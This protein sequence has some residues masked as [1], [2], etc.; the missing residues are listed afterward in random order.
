V[1]TIFVQIASYRDAQLLPTLRDLIAKANRPGRLR[2]GICWQRDETESLEELAHDP[3]LRVIDV[4]YRDAQGACWARWLTQ[5]LYESEDYT[6]QI[7]SHHRFVRGWDD[8]LIA[9]LKSTG[10]EKPILTAYAP[11]FEPSDT[12]G[13]FSQQ[14]W[15]LKFLPVRHHS[16]DDEAHIPQLGRCLR[17]ARGRD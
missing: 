8:E 5:S 7:D 3:R 4:N 13:V 6:L 14:P 17:L 9:M 10:S 2:F 1:S 12:S 16:L 15:A 11:P